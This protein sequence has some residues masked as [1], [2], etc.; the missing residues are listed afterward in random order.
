MFKHPFATPIHPRQYIHEYSQAWCKQFNLGRKFGFIEF[1]KLLWFLGFLC[2]PFLIK[3]QY[4]PDLASMGPWLLL[5]VV[6]V[7]IAL[8]AHVIIPWCYKFV[9]PKWY[10][11]ITSYEQGILALTEKK[12]EKYKTELKTYNENVLAALAAYCQ[13]KDF[14][15]TTLPPGPAKLRY[16]YSGIAKNNINIEHLIELG[17]PE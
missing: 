10:E 14:V 7:S 16:T 1:V 8:A 9:F 2:L 12:I 3:M 5:I 6:C 13:K 17:I 15:F 4:G 11:E